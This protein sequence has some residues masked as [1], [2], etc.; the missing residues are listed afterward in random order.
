[1]AGS[2]PLAPLSSCSGTVP[3]GPGA[4]EQCAAAAAAAAVEAVHTGAPVADQSRA[5]TIAARC[6]VAGL[7]A[8]RVKLPAVPGKKRRH[9]RRYL[10]GA[11]RGQPGRRSGGNGLRRPQFRTDPTQISGRRLHQLGN[12]DQH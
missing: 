1:M 12:H 4:A 9:R 7:H 6:A 10:V 5:T 2:T 11:R 8:N 3:A